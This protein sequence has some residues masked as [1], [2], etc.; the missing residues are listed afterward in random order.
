MTN[1]MIGLG[2]VDP[3][4]RNVVA[5]VPSVVDG[6]RT[7]FIGGNLPCRVSTINSFIE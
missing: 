3:R 4:G 7:N 1:E 2:V 5:D 6:C